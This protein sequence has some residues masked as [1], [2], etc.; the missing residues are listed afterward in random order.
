MLRLRALPRNA[1][2]LPR[3]RFMTPCSDNFR[4]GY[5]DVF[6]WHVL[7]AGAAAGTDFLDGVHDFLAFRH[8]AEHGIAI[9]LRGG[10]VKLRKLLLDTL[11]KNC[12]VA[13]SGTEVRA[14]AMV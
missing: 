1:G 7:M 12:A 8:L 13:E 11:M 5:D 10:A 6:H 3:S 9:A 2:I 14:M 4:L